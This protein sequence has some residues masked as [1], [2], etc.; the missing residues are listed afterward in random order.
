MGTSKYSR[1]ELYGGAIFDSCVVDQIKNTKLLFVK[2]FV[3][4]KSTL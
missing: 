3:L 1:Q 2:L 4:L